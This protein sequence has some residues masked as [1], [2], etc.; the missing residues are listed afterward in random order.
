MTES[1]DLA[2]L[3]AGSG[4]LGAALAAARLGL[5][6]VLVEKSD[7]VGGTATRGGVHGWESGVGATGLP[8]DLYRRLKRLPLAVGVYSFGRHGSWPKPTDQVPFPGGEHVVDPS[9]GYADTLLRHVAPGAA[10]DEAHRRKHWHGVI[11]EPDA[12]CRVVEEMLA[13]TGRCTLLKQTAFTDVRTEGGRLLSLRLSDGREVQA[14]AY[15][16]ATGDGLLC[17]A[18]GCEAM[19]GQ[20]SREVFGEPSAPEQPNH[21]VNSVSLIY[22]VTPTDT[23]GVEPLPEGMPAECWWAPRF[24]WAHMPRYPCG[25]FSVN[26]LPTMEGEEFLGRGYADAYEECR[27]RVI[28]HW[29]HAQTVFPEFRGYR[30]S[31]IAP[32]LGIRESRRIVGEYVLREHD[33]SAGLSAQ[34]HDDIIA[35]ADHAQDRHGAGGGCAELRQPYGVPFRCLIPR[36]FTNLLIACRAASFSSLA[37][38]SCRLSRTMMQL[39]H[40]AGTAAAL[41]RD[42]GVDLP[43][44]PPERLRACLREQHVQLEY[45]P[46]AALLDHL[47]HEDAP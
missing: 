6:V 5:S 14:G 44:V 39:G 30:R 42:L 18:C 47:R 15:V 12:Y 37:A 3:G 9:L 35:I 22:R 28:A 21:R 1:Y 43:G 8:F 10:S 32:L 19:V 33:L 4:G 16:D 17:L 2:V 45:P 13:E 40:A 20:E 36:G 26:M 7:T 11:F 41:A 46:P 31:W 27:R 24:P 23:P 25:D 34:E 38:S 29:H